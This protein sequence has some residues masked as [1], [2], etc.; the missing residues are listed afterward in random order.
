[1][2]ARWLVLH[3]PIAWSFYMPPCTIAVTLLTGSLFG[4]GKSDKT[5]L[6]EEMALQVAQMII[7]DVTTTT[8]LHDPSSEG[9]D[10]ESSGR[11][12][13]P[14]SSASFQLWQIR[15][16]SIYISVRFCVEQQCTNFIGWGLVNVG[17]KLLQSGWVWWLNIYQQSDIYVC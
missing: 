13:E 12:P 1:M 5:R 16:S 11:D 15:P 2:T 4:R 17:L 9:H 3:C 10:P 6:D 8:R 14:S 7:D